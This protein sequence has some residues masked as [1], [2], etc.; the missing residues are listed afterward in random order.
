MS[1]TT[2]PGRAALAAAIKD[3]PIHMVWGRGE[4]W[5]DTAQTVPRTFTDDTVNVGR[6]KIGSV[7]VSAADGVGTFTRD[8]DYTVNPAAGDV[9][10]IDGGAIAPGAPVLITFVAARPT[11]SVNATSLTAEV[12]RRALTAV[13]FCTPDPAGA[14]IA[15]S[16]RFTPSPTPTNNLHFRFVFDFG[17]A[18]TETIREVGVVIDSVMQAGLPAGQMYFQPSEVATPGI[19]LLVENVAPIVRSAATRETFEFV[20][21]F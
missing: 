9:T 14:I 19:L 21:T 8:A 12:G 2:K 16:G 7:T 17:D 11:P 4:A 6:T 10:R 3:R 13:Q 15:P 18:A 1:V 20:H 5:W